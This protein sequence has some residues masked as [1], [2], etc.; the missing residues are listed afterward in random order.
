[1]SKTLV[2]T[3]VMPLELEMFERFI[4]YY[5]EGF[6]Y[7]DSNDDVTMYVTLNLNPKLTD[8]DKS[9]LKPQWFIDKFTQSMCG[10]K[11]HLQIIVDESVWGTTQQKR[12]VSFLDYDYFIF[13]DPDIS[14]HEQQ[15]KLQIMAAEQ[16]SAESDFFVLS[17]NIPKWWDGSWDV[18][19]H[20]NNRNDELG[21]FR[22]KQTF[23]DTFNQNPNEMGIRRI[24]QFK[25]GCGMHTLY[26]KKFWETFRIPEE[27]GGYGSEDTFGMISSSEAVKFGIDVRQYVL[28]GLYITEDKDETHREPSYKDKISVFRVKED[29]KAK[30]MEI[31]PM[32]IT[33]LGNSLLNK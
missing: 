15:L 12:D 19:V 26:S 8:W 3:H 21:K 2:V 5:K 13:V 18:L 11:S 1:M 6:K 20:P 23:I 25:F 14:V 9:E 24:G 29:G 4:S 32:V 16:I 27:F 28:D 33:R 22:L 30:S 17:P 7:L 31:M 10:I